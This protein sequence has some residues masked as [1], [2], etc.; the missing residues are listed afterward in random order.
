VEKL[1]IEDRVVSNIRALNQSE[2]INEIAKLISGE[3]ITDSA[4]ISA[5]ELLGI[6]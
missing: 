6:N 3:K 1:K 4:I 2:K 5:K